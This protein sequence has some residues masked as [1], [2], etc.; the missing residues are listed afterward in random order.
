MRKYKLILNIQP[1]SF[2]KMKVLAI[3]DLHFKTTSSEE[4]EILIKN[5]LEISQNIKPDKI[6]I[7]G[8]TLHNHSVIN[9]YPF[10]RAT[11]FIIE[12]SKLAPVYLLIGNHDRP[13]HKIFMTDEHPFIALK[14]FQSITVVDKTIAEYPLV[15]VPYVET[16]RF[17][18]AIKDIDLTKTKVIFA[19]QEFLGSVINDQGDYWPENYPLIISGH[20]H[21]TF[22]LQSNIF[23]IG[24]PIQHS[25]YD[26]SNNSI[27]LLNIDDTIELT[28]IPLNVPR[29]KIL[30]IKEE[31]INEI[32]NKLNKDEKYLIIVETKQNII[33]KF[34]N[35]NI[36][37]NVNIIYKYV[38]DV[39]T[40]PVS[41]NIS[42]MQRLK[43]K[44][45]DKK[46]Y[47]CLN[48][49]IEDIKNNS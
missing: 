18:E 47:E 22:Y 42:F 5:I 2:R 15:F 24:T 25:F 35:F 43:E 17:H 38:P 19:H 32:I 31:E 41:N 7:L 4:S 44:I 11:K 14:Y 1:S 46:T 48:K 30:R 49:I 20:I 10:I 45:K 26:N 29:K 33:K 16:G 36:R 39:I 6:I 40:S 28:E 3:G 8:D 27:C 37:D 12:L 21:K 34:E 23:Y 9:L 13:N